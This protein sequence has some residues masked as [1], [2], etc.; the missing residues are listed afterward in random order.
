MLQERLSWVLKSYIA[1]PLTSLDFCASAFVFR[2]CSNRRTRFDICFL[3]SFNLRNHLSS[4]QKCL[5]I[6]DCP[7]CSECRGL[8]IYCLFLCVNLEFMG[9]IYKLRHHSICFYKIL[10]EIID[11]CKL[12]V[13]NTI[14]KRKSYFVLGDENVFKKRSILFAALLCLALLVSACGNDKESNSSDS[15]VLVITADTVSEPA[16]FLQNRFAIG[17]N[18]VF[19]ADAIDGETGKQAEGANLKVHLSTGDVLDMRYGEH[20]AGSGVAFWTVAYKVTENTPTGVLDYYITAELGDKKGEFRPFNVAPSLLTIID[21]SQ[22]THDA[23]ITEPDTATADLT[24]VETNQTVDIIASNFELK[25]PTGENVFYVKAGE[26]VTVN[27]TIESGY[28]GIVIDG[29]DVNIQGEGTATFTPEAGEYEVY[30][31]VFCGDGHGI[32]TAKIVAIE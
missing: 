11:I 19:R 10:Y 28:H 12:S 31:S 8:R 27:L 14:I 1:I 20:P 22:A 7:F 4:N 26:E 5:G 21:P 2:L 30:C 9:Y 17:E 32:M 13:Y 18:I 25:S 29:T 15:N 3:G 24:N 16:C 6:L 23:E